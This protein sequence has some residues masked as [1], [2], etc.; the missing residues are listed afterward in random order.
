MRV[1]FVTFPA[2]AHLFPIVPL[3]WALQAAGHEVR[4]ASHSGVVEPD[5]TATIAATGLTPVPLGPGTELAALARVNA[6][7]DQTN[8]PTLALDPAAGGDWERTRSYV[9]GLLSLYYPPVAADSGERWAMADELVAFARSW[10][11]DLVLWDPLCPPAPI[12]AR[13]CGAAHARVLWGLDNLAWMRE[14]ALR[15]PEGADR[16]PLVEWLRPLL[17]RYGDTFDEEVLT[18]QCTLDL[19]PER[20]RLPLDRRYQ[21]VRRVPYNGAGVVPGWLAARPHRPR[22]CLTLGVS[23]RKLFT[24][25]Q[26]FSVAE[27][28]A[29]VAELDVELVATL[30]SAQLAGVDELPPN[31]R[32][33]EYLP[34]NLL[35]PTCAAVIHHG[36]GGTYAAAVAHRLPQL[37]IPVPKWD[38]EVTARHVVE[39]GAGLRVD[40]PFTVADVRDGLLRLLHEPRFRAGA[41]S[42]HRDM[43]AAPSPVE[44]VPV[45]E[46]L[47]ARHRRPRPEGVRSPHGQ[48]STCAYS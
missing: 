46:R 41:E 29:L 8:R 37:V 23:T 39:R 38:E 32:I 17:D 26:G 18:G 45:L 4:V 12:A 24:E 5:M 27:L 2:T 31:V 30:N 16:D 3:A 10:G 9:I 34:L 48:E 13:A 44:V 28:F 14:M 43:L 42:L 21:A 25:H 35:L 36:G 20:M 22:V 7:A 47:T 19:V 6:A 33:V 40:E 15:R 11:P 1:L